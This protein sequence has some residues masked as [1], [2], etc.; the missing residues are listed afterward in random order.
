MRRKLQEKDWHT[1]LCDGHDIGGNIGY[2]RRILRIAYGKAG[3]LGTMPVSAMKGEHMRDV[4]RMISGIIWGGLWLSMT[5]GQVSAQSPSPGR[6]SIDHKGFTKPQP[7][8]QSFVIEATITSAAGIRKAQVFCRGA[9][10]RDFTA[11]PMEPVDGNRYRALVPDWM[12]AGSGVEYYI[13]ATDQAGQ[14]TSQGFVGFPLTVRL[15]PPRQLSQE[16]RVKALDDT[17][18]TIRKSREIPTPSPSGD[19]LQDPR[20]NRNRY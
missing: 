11:L 16:E 6:L 7:Q 18:E 5:V 14:S 1:V 8:G 10:G 17:L 4:R 12:T 2:T 3:S 13:T 19:A 20:L 15:L 9:G